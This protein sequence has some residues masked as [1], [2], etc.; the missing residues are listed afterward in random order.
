MEREKAFARVEQVI[1]GAATLVNFEGTLEEILKFFSDSGFSIVEV[2]CEEP[3]FNPARVE[4]EALRR[5]AE[6]AD[7]LSLRLALHS[8]YID[9]NL[10][11]L[12]DYTYKA[13]LKATR[14]C[15]ELAG[16]LDACYLTVHC[17]TLSRDYPPGL[18]SKAWVRSKRAVSSLAK[19]ASEE[20]VVLGL[21]NK[22][23]ASNRHLLVSPEE[24]T[25]FLEGLDSNVGV[26]YDVGHANT[27][28]I[29]EE[30]HLRFISSLK[31][32]LV[33]FHVHDNDG[34]SDQHL[35]VGEGK[36]RFDVLLP[37]M[38]KI[39]VPVILEVHSLR[40]LV[41]SRKKLEEML[42]AP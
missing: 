13:S 3:L 11:S 2:K 25:S 12:C 23:R 39:E 10:A 26:V 42:R 1:I 18:F 6:L 32:Y 41:E 5:L 31:D 28:G 40:G 8:S 4:G 35:A 19:Y 33:A 22:E 17:G 29:T 9:I 27:W 14:K 37:F 20:G 21:E 34:K 15:V 7:S 36:I 38:R 16:L 24:F 30:G